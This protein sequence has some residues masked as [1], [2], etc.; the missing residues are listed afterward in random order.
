[1]LS[2]KGYGYVFPLYL[3][4]KPEGLF[5]NGTELI[6]TENFT[7]AFRQFIDQHYH[8]HYPP[9]EIL[10]YIYAVLHSPTY[11][12]KYAEFLKIDFPRIPFTK[13]GET[14]ETLSKL[15]WQLVQAHLL[16]EIPASDLGAYGGEGDNTV[17]KPDYRKTPDSERLYINKT[18]YFEPVPEAVY[19]FQIGGYQVLDKYLKDRKGR[20]LTLSEVK[21]IKQ[22]IKVLAFTIEQMHKID[23][24]SSE[25][26]WKSLFII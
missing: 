20:T 24:I 4:E 3:Y 26:I 6:K 10:G 23:E 2:N 8:T 12:A 25:W 13:D 14:F 18:Q 1:M 16:H 7:K 21:N 17:I 22:I 15:G 9:E 11:R 5:A 19:R